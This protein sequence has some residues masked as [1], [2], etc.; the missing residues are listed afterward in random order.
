MMFSPRI[1]VIYYSATGNMHRLAEAFTDGAFDAGA[2]VRLRKV[3]ELAPAQAIDAN[4]AWRAHLEATAHVEEASLEDLAWAN[5]LALGTPT[6]FGNV[7]SQLKQ[8]LDTAGGLWLAGRLADMAVTGFT[9]SMDAHGGQ[10]STLLALYHTMFHW[11]SVIVPPGWVD[12][13]VAHAAGGNPYGISQVESEA[14]DPTYAKAVAEA[15]RAHGRRLTE[16]AR[17]LA[18]LQSEGTGR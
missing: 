4:P 12:Y 10:E 6:R 14:A 16:T 9:G 2:Q 5:G 17:A 7:S 8:F 15:A 1:A 13:D 3:A 18:P 11:G